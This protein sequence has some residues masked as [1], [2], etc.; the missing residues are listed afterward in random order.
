MP[1]SSFEPSWNQLAPVGQRQ[2]KKPRSTDL[3]RGEA[4]ERWNATLDRHDVLTRGQMQQDLLYVRLSEL[5]RAGS[6][7]EAY[8]LAVAAACRLRM[9]SMCNHAAR[10]T[11][12]R[13]LDGMADG[14]VTFRKPG[15]P[16]RAQV[17]AEM[18]AAGIS[19]DEMARCKEITG[20]PGVNGLRSLVLAKELLSV[21]GNQAGSLVCAECGSKAPLLTD[22]DVGCSYCAT[23]WVSY[24]RSRYEE[25]L[26]K[27]SPASSTLPGS[28]AP[29]GATAA[30]PENEQEL[31]DADLLAESLGSLSPS[32]S[33]ASTQA[34]SDLLTAGLRALTPCPLAP[35]D[36][37]VLFPP[38]AL[39]TPEDETTIDDESANQDVA[40]CLG[41]NVSPSHLSP[42]LL[43]NML[44][45]ECSPLFSESREQQRHEQ[46]VR[47][48]SEMVAKGLGNEDG[49]DV[50][51]WVSSDED[52]EADDNDGDDEVARGYNRRQGEP[53]RKRSRVSATG[54]T[55]AGR[56]AFGWTT[57][58]RAL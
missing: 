43:W 48:D 33:D 42:G 22:P 58:E 51:E 17:Q 55:A 54:W 30:E 6:H 45:N 36:P 46:L 2:K 1:S 8:E 24:D 50:V 29:G 39:I 41:G 27:S 44:A 18:K 32:R 5:T 3:A 31:S 25:L 16:T 9:S 7:G 21:A 19:V 56:S 10:E 38:P 37:S 20:L 12:R 13:K 52:S 57:A 28:A 35:E 14:E 53:R 15:R 40:A 49:F 23:C 11:V 4:R 34:V 26:A 47:V